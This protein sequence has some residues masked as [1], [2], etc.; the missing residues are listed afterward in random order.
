MKPKIR[1]EGDRVFRTVEVNGQLVERE[2]PRIS[3]KPKLAPPPTIP[4]RLWRRVRLFFWR[5]LRV[6]LDNGLREFLPHLSR[7][8]NSYDGD[9]WI[10]HP[11]TWYSRLTG[12][13]EGVGHWLL[14][15][16]NLRENIRRN[17][18]RK[19]SR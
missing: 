10:L 3:K 12:H 19:S 15:S 9:F 14:T 8:S 13:G 4:Q 5:T 16:R 6:Q 7:G 17:P 2:I 1:Y 11:P 18:T